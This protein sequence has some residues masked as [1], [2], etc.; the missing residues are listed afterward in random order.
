MKQ[1]AIITGASSGI[2]LSTAKLLAEKGYKV[3]GICR[4]EFFCENITY[5]QGDV[6]D[7]ARIA[8]IFEE[9]YK[10]ESKIDVVINNAGMGISGAVEYINEADVNKI[11]EVNFKGV[12]NVCAVATKYLR[13][14]KG[15]VIN[16]SSVAAITGIAFQACYC[17][18]KGAIEAFSLAYANEVRSF[19]IKVT[20][21]RPGDTKTGFTDSRV[22]TETTNNEYGERIN[23]KV[24]QM[25]DYERK[26]VEPIKVSKTILKI[27]KKKNPPPVCTVGVLYKFIA[28]LIKLLPARL[29]NWLVYKIY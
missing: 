5:F 4:R 14:T 23:K 17:A 21:V 10:I 29:V 7:R 11:L 27:C 12:V 2:G 18:T 25:E 6:T 15:K 26:G 13:E 16:V 28:M 19:G 8:E 22:K 9:I 24:S 3:Y 1:V 20:C